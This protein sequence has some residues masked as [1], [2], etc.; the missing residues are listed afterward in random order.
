M[1]S[2]RKRT[3]RPRGVAR[4]RWATALGGLAVSAL[5]VGPLGCEGIKGPRGEKRDV[6]PKR[7]GV[8]R[9]ATFTN[10]RSLDAAVAFDTASSA[11]EDLIYDRLVTYG[12]G[13]DIV[14]QLAERIEVSEDGKTYTFPIRRG[15]RFHDGEEL[16]AA[17]FKRSLERALH[18][19]TPCP[20]PSFYDRIKGYKEFHAGKAEELSGL[21]V[22]GE[23]ELKVELRVPDATLLHVLALPI[24]AP[25]C[26]NAGKVWSREFSKNAC[27]TGPFKLVRYEH[28]A[29]IKVVRHDAYWKKGEPYL[30]EVEWFLAMQSFTQRFKFEDGEFD[31][32][33]EFNGTDSLLFRSHPEWKKHGEWQAAMT[34]AGVFMNTEMPPFD[35]RHFRRAVAH[36]LNFEQVAMVRPGHVEKHRRVVPEAIM[37]RSPGM[38]LQTFDLDKAREEMKLA[39]YE[40]GYPEE[41]PYLALIDSFGEQSAQI[42]QQQLAKIGIRVRIQLVGWPTFLS[43]SHRR[44]TVMMG[45]SGWHADFPDPSD[46][47]EPILTTASIQDEN[48][49]NQ[50]FFSNKELDELL[51]VARE[52]TDP[53]E[54][55][56]LYTRAEEIIAAEAPWAVG[57]SY[58]YFEAWH[59]YVHGYRPHPVLSQAVRGMWFDHEQK[60]RRVAARRGRCWS[61]L[62]RS[63]GCPSDRP[64]TTLAMVTGAP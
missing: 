48:S 50:A 31:Y 55:Q 36:A 11:I 45:T 38:K 54:R 6:Q 26:K 62:P 35:N 22:S 59:P 57:Y 3:D 34:S 37:P 61:P 30:D 44:K 15:V 17:D 32:M 20:V 29:S 49:Q 1:L 43:K 51:V 56:R 40:G 23:Y 19:D 64:R 33:R 46:F 27:G 2:I 41:I 4:G 8:L 63:S 21:R 7:G 13:T 12:E 24:A 60:A 52:S 47:F 9:T 58:R 14:P 42:Y 10:V 28:H 16:K 18:K 53:K 25:V 39:G 5:L